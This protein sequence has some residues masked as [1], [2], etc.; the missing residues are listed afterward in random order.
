MKGCE[1]GMKGQGWGREWGGCSRWEGCGQ[2]EASNGRSPRVHRWW[3]RRSFKGGTKNHKACG[4]WDRVEGKYY[5]VQG[6]ANESRTEK[7]ME[8]EQ[9]EK[10]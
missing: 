10:V 4:L 6:N 1:L 9:M 3:K 2:Q 5:K 7:I 8:M